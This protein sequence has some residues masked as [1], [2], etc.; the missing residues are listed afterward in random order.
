MDDAVDEYLVTTWTIP[1]TPGP[2]S[3]GVWLLEARSG[4]ARVLDAS[5]TDVYFGVREPGSDSYLVLQNGPGNHHLRRLDRVA[6]HARLS[7][8]WSAGGAGGSYIA[9]DA[10]NRHFVVSNSETGWAIFRRGGTPELVGGFTHHGNGPHPRQPAS[11]PH[12]ALFA[13]DG[14]AVLAADMGADELLAVPFDAVG[15]GLGVPRVVYRARPGAGP[16]HIAMVGPHIYVL[17]ELDNTV[18]VLGWTSTGSLSPLQRLSTLP[19]AFDGESYASHLHVDRKRGV[20]YA[21]NRGHNS[22]VVLQLR[23][24]GRLG[25]R[26]W[27]DSGGAWPWYFRIDGDRMLVANNRSDTVSGLAVSPDG[28][29]RLESEAVIP[30]PMFLIPWASA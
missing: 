30:R 19:E 7:D 8:P 23:P 6:C 15:G 16:R 18:E 21:A 28:R 12:C 26:L 4:R 29:L 24:D 10:L 1:G 25:E 2:Q 17:N 13:A 5:V 9:F 20:V 27:V 22:I 11:H 14:T 3:T